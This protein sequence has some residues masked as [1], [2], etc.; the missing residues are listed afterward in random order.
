MLAKKCENNFHP[1]N[2]QYI[3]INIYE[4]ALLLLYIY[5]TLFLAK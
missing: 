3:Y 2:S 1:I 4:I 5:K